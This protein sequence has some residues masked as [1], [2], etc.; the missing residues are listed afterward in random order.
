MSASDL[1][2]THLPFNIRG[3]LQTMSEHMDIELGFISLQ[4]R[5]YASTMRFQSIKILYGLS[6][7]MT[8]CLN[9]VFPLK[10][11][12]HQVISFCILYSIIFTSLELMQNYIFWSSLQ[13]KVCVLLYKYV[14]F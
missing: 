12:R 2:R 14:P 11:T 1:I 8:F 3:Q 9:V 7:S 4:D 13:E 6:N 5:P 10:A